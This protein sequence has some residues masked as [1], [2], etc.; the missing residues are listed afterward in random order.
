M[1]SLPVELGICEALAHFGTSLS[2]AN[3]VPSQH[4][5]DAGY[6]QGSSSSAGA[7]APGSG[8]A[9]D[10]SPKSISDMTVGPLADGRVSANKR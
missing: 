7:A 2:M 5:A 4:G 3:V 10:L 6:M 9:S 1:N 8:T